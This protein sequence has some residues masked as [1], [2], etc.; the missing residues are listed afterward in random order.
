MFEEALN[1]KN[2]VW[3]LKNELCQAQQDALTIQALKSTKSNF[4]N[5]QSWLDKSLVENEEHQTQLPTLQDRLLVIQ[6][7]LDRL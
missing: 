6:A 1:A 7:Y 2:E 3:R 4:V 5:M